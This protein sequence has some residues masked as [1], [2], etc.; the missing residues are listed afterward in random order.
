ML[1]II[2]MTLLNFLISYINSKIFRGLGYKYSKN[3]IKIWIFISPIGVRDMIIEQQAQHEEMA[4]E[5]QARSE[6]IIHI[7]V[8]QKPLFKIT[9]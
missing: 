5:L 1:K 8:I 3:Y 4:I 6:M 7:W 9:N 2:Q